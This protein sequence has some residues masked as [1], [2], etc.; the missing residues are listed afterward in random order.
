MKE[1]TY[2]RLPI[3]ALLRHVE[4]IRSEASA[5]GDDPDALVGEWT[6]QMALCI[7]TGILAGDEFLE[8]IRAF[9]D[10]FG[11][12]TAGN[13]NARKKNRRKAKESEDED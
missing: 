5:R 8:D 6:R 3:G 7:A 12:G 4:R 9:S 2:V 10:S 1:R 11:G 13:Q